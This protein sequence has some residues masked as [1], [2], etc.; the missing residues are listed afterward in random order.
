[1]I[2]E[3][4]SAD[5]ASRG[6]FPSELLSRALWWNGPHWLKLPASEWPKINKSQP[7]NVT[8]V[9]ELQPIACNILIVQEPFDRLSFFN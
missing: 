1:M 3:Y 2:S 6:M 5:C 4:N 8:E 9:G 7:S